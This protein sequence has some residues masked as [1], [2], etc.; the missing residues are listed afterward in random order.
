MF[1]WWENPFFIAPLAYL[2]TFL[3]VGIPLYFFVSYNTEHQ[4]EICSQYKQE[5][6]SLNLWEK[7]KD[8]EEARI[9]IEQISRE[10]PSELLR[11]EN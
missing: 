7:A 3:I 10:C 4:E 11:N 5:I 1:E 2:A 6:N 8:N 9:R